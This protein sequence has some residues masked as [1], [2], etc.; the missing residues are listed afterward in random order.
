MPVSAAFSVVAGEQLYTLRC[1]FAARDTTRD[2]K[3]LVSDGFFH[4]AQSSLCCSGTRGFVISF[5]S[6]GLLNGA[7]SPPVGAVALPPPSLRQPGPRAHAPRRPTPIRAGRCRGSAGSGNGGGG[8]R[9]R[10]EPPAAPEPPQRRQDRPQVPSSF[11]AGAYPLRPSSVLALGL[12]PMAHHTSPTPR[13]ASPHRSGTTSCTAP[14][15]SCGNRRGCLGPSATISPTSPTPVCYCSPPPSP[16][17]AL[18]R[19]P[20]ANPRLAAAGEV[21]QRWR[22]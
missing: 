10:R 13:S 2:N 3:R 17:T 8:R 1:I 21:A 11:A 19:R 14:S 18:R 6:E 16:P 9:G 12:F 15:P 20:S 22:R 7:L 5:G 4:C